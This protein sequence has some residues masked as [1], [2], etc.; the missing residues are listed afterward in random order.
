MDG[1]DTRSHNAGGDRI[2]TNDIQFMSARRQGRAHL[3]RYTI[4]DLQQA[5]ARALDGERTME[6]LRVDARGLDGLLDGKAV[7]E[8]VQQHHQNL[9]IL[10][11]AAGR[12]DRQERL[13]VP[14]HDSRRQGGARSFP[15]D[16]NIGTVRVQIKDRHAVAERHARIARH[17]G[18]AQQPAGTRGATEQIALLVDHF[19]GGGVG[20][21]G[22]G[23]S[24]SNV[25]NVQDDSDGGVGEEGGGG[26]HT[27]S[28]QEYFATPFYILL[29]RRMPWLVVLLIL[30]SFSA[31]I[32]H[33]YDEYLTRNLVFSFFIPM[34]VGTG[35][36]AGNQCS[37]MI[38]RALALGMSGR[39]VLRVIRKECP[40]A[41]VTAVILG[42]CAFVRVILE[43]PN[44]Q[45]EA[46]AIAL[47]LGSS[48]LISIALG[49]AFS[50]GIGLLNRCDPADGAAP[51]LTTISDL[52]GIALLCG[53]ATSM[54]P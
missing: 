31:S 26:G 48:V 21:G 20:G 49:I 8:D 35:G 14:Q 39:E 11:V 3:W 53:F 17:I 30:Q 22:S 6:M 15:T 47:T 5:R 24:S 19:D 42:L 50:Y 27:M 4:L 23:S 44:D 33:R 54:V 43:Y 13:A 38:T 25:L 29:F 36:N 37:V 40:T 1:I 2:G 12:A 28:L 9:L 46:A 18:A 7:D 51:L 16:Q 32:L 10:I 34:I 52:I 45:V 41:L